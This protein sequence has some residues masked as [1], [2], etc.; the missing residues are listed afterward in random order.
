MKKFLGLLSLVLIFCAAMTLT[1]CLEDEHV[2]TLTR[3]EAKEATCT[4]EGNSEYWECT[5]CDKYFSDENAE[6]EITDKTSVI[7]PKKDHSWSEQVTKVATYT[8]AGSVTNTC[9]VCGETTTETVDPIEYEADIT[10]KA[11]GSIS[12]AIS[13]AKDGDII[14]VEEGTYAEQLL[15]SDKDITIIGLGNV[16]V[17]GPEDYSEI[18]S[19][20]KITGE[21]MDYSAIVAVVNSKVTLENVTVKG[22]PEKSS[23]VYQLTHATRYAG[24]AAINSDL[25]MNYVAIKDIIQN[26]SL[27]GVQNGFGIYAVATDADLTLTMRYGEISNFQKG[28]AIIRSSISNFVFEGNVVKGAGAQGT[29][30]QNGL[31]IDC[32]ASVTG[33][34][35][36]DMS[37]V[38]EPVN[39]WAYGSW[40]VY[41]QTSEKEVTVKDNTF[42]SCDNGV[43]GFESSTVVSGNVFE[44]M[45]DAEGC[46]DE[47]LQTASEE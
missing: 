13:S 17:C 32:A 24:V 29:I 20:S 8:R 23:L 1:G 3:H 34:A 39:E 41:V 16:V 43:L 5:E 12:A 11:G 4:E 27:M 30:A 45:T 7:I 21:S 28:A 18:Q 25:T 46:Y 47:Y 38:P 2:H 15:I 31:Q 9:T 37:Y 22:D 19:V 44:N 33:N 14:T 36:S 26:V 40:A 6:N 35:F 42:K 10:V